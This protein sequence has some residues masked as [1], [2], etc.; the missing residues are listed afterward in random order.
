MADLADPSDL[1]DLDMQ[2]SRTV[3]YMVR[4]V[5]H[6]AQC[7]PG[8]PVPRGEVVQATGTPDPY[9]RKIVQV[10]SRAGIVRTTRGPRGGY[11]L[12]VPAAELTLL[13]VVEAGSGD[14]CMNQC[15]M[16]PSACGLSGTC[17]VH[18]VW[19]EVRRQA[20]ETLAA[21]TFA[22]LARRA[23]AGRVPE[24]APPGGRRRGRKLAASGRGDRPRPQVG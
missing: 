20:R 5:L 2:L 8:S 7:E 19:Q 13:R 16:D 17:V 9:F 4:C 14:V 1:A 15:A 18:P 3:D 6:L 23:R 22:E 21:V 10:L 12:A 11:C 24:P